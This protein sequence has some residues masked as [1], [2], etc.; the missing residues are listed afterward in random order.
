MG[1]RLQRGYCGA[2]WP[3][4]PNARGRE[5]GRCPRKGPS[6]GCRAPWAANLEINVPGPRWAKGEAC[7]NAM[8]IGFSNSILAVRVTMGSS[9]REKK[10]RSSRRILLGAEHR[11]QK[12]LGC[13]KVPAVSTRGAVSHLLHLGY[14]WR[15]RWSA[16]CSPGH[17]RTLG[18]LS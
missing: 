6:S 15:Q 2:G 8:P 7:A 14:Q 5:W 11:P 13:C 17:K 18:F 1:R 10:P 4:L 16:R 9:R 3:S 12:V